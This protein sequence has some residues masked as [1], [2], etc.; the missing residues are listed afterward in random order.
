MKK[1]ADI[2]IGANFGDEG[3]GLVT[4]FLAHKNGIDGIV[5]RHNGGAQAG[6]TVTDPSGRRHVF[7]HFSSGSFSGAKTFLSRYF[8]CN[9]ILFFQE[10]HNLEA[11]GLNPS[12]YVDPECIISTPYDMMINQIAEE[13]RGK[14]RH[15][16]CGVGFGETIE[17]NVYPEYRI[18]VEDCYNKTALREKL[19]DIRCKWVFLRGQSLGFS[20]LDALW[21]ERLSSDDILDW[22]LDLVEKF[23]DSV[24]LTGTNI[25]RSS[26]SVIF[27]GAQGL[28]LDQDYGWF[29][30][31][32]RSNTG[33]KNAL[34][35]CEESGID[36]ID[37]TYITR[38]YLTRHGAGPL[39]AELPEKPYEGIQDETNIHN[40]Y[41]GSLRF[42]YLDFN[43]LENAI[44]NDLV[45]G[46]GAF[47][48]NHKIAVTCLDQVGSKHSYIENSSL[49]NEREETFIGNLLKCLEIDQIL[50]SYGPTREN[51]VEIKQSSAFCANIRRSIS[52]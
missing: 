19:L 39:S 10:K 46:K 15:G 31:V 52:Y 47:K 17:R 21:I 45:Y 7:K 28:L 12:V 14:A 25:I 51:V 27:E 43:M 11:L 3:K 4:D 20:Q 9:P 33:I 40:K 41:Q 2:V 6:H 44:R 50:M 49:H 42:A 38:A 30:H 26:S 1:R 36:Q 34:A 23:L 13:T 48:L 35:L 32:T 8:V 18:T 5:V 37:I 24:R 16:S 29:P 22:Y